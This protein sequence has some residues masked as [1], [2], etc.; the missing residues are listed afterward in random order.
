MAPDRLLKKNR[1]LSVKKKD[2][3]PVAVKRK[4]NQ[5][6][7]HVVAKKIKDAAQATPVAMA[8]AIILHVNVLIFPHHLHFL[9][10]KKL[11]LDWLKLTF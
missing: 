6:P 10:Y 3:N 11:L 2:L 4:L 1:V 8:D 9:Q 5:I 7:I